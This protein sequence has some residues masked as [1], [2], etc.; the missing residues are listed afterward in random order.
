MDFKFSPLIGGFINRIELVAFHGYDLESCLP[1]LKEILGIWAGA[2]VMAQWLRMLAVFP[3]GL[4]S[5]PTTP[6]Q[7]LPVTSVCL[8]AITGTCSHGIC[9]QTHTHVHVNS[10]EAYFDLEKD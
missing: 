3:E 2:G 4:S 7:E 10:K 6:P 9:I 8:L 5:V 1:P